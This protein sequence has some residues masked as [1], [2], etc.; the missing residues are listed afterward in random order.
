M[1]EFGPLGYVLAHKVAA[2][3]AVAAFG[4]K[5]GQPETYTAGMVTWP[6]QETASATLAGSYKPGRL[7][8]GGPIQSRSIPLRSPHQFKARS[9]LA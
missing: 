2:A 5:D 7:N 4:N 9:V 6:S 8:C 1:G 3:E